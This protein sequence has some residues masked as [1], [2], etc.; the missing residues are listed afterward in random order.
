MWQQRPGLICL[1][2]VGGCALA[3]PARGQYDDEDGG[4]T[5]V[6]IQDRQFSMAHEFT[7]ATGTY[8]LDAFKKG[9][10]LSGR[11]TLHFDELNAWEIVGGAYS[12][13]VDSGLADLL[14]GNFGVQAEALPE[15][16]V[17]ADTNYV[18]K[19]LYGK[20]T[21]FNSLILYQEILLAGG[22]TV[23]YWS[24][25]SFR[26]G[27]DVGAAIRF[28][29]W[30]WLSVR[31]DLRHALVMNG[32]PFLDPNAQVDGVLYLGGGVSFN[33]GGGA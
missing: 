11:Y 3:S 33:V 5:A 20:F 13:N 32:V 8:P 25:G 30:D 29:V 1:A 9:V 10:A 28:F 21:L 24:D 31:F 12:L 15:L 23:T 6:V 22:L 2:L 16:V 4:G 18:M 19:P 26:P 7:L 17:V 14:R 27:P